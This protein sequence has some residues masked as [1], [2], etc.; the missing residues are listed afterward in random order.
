[1]AA[2]GAA[3]L[4]P[5]DH[6]PAALTIEAC[7]L[8]ICVRSVAGVHT[9]TAFPKDGIRACFD[10]GLAHGRTLGCSATFVTHGHMD[11][12]AALAHHAGLRSMARLPPSAVFAPAAIAAE[13]SSA[14]AALAAGYLIARAGKQLREDL[15]QAGPEAIKAA[16]AAG[17]TV[18]QPTLEILAAVTGDT[19]AAGMLAQPAFRCAPVLVTECTLT[20]PD[21]GPEVAAERGHTHVADLAEAWAGRQLTGRV[22]VLTHLSTR[23]GPAGHC[24]LVR[25][26]LEEALSARGVALR[27]WRVDGGG[28]AKF[29]AGS[30]F[31][32]DV[33]GVDG[34]YAPGA[35]TWPPRACAAAVGILCADCDDDEAAGWRRP[36]VVCAAHAHQL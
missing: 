22:L 12:I 36:A 25:A 11:H 29:A 35:D 19:I 1:M 28:D 15:Q 4:L 9:A 18:T 7:G 16:S 30:A 14:V 6:Q 3:C 8:T 20:G 21:M 17:E 2:S 24:A 27:G 32:G 33:P 10:M 31:A 26:A 5:V 13:L 23:E 34:E